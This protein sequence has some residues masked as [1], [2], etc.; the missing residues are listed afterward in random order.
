MN[1]KMVIKNEN[2]DVMTQRQ[3]K[4]RQEMC[5][6]LKSNT[7]PLDFKKGALTGLFLSGCLRYKQY[8][9]ISKNMK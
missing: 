7:F 2:D 1:Y 3:L 8:E 9:R 4:A 5:F 6:I